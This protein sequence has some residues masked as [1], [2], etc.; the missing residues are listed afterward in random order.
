MRAQRGLWYGAPLLIAAACA[1][2]GAVDE[3]AVER[4]PQRSP[5]GA[6]ALELLAP[7][8]ALPALSLR[9]SLQLVDGSYRARFAGEVAHP[10]VQ[11]EIPAV[12]GDA[13][14]V[15]DGRSAVAMRVRPRSVDSTVPS[16]AS[17]AAERVAGDVV[18]GKVLYRDALGPGSHRVHAPLPGGSEELV[19]V[20]RAAGAPVALAWEVE[21]GGA[22]AGVRLVSGT[23]EVLDAGGAPRLRMAR[24][25]LQDAAGTRRW[26]QV[27]LGGCAHDTSP[28]PP[29]G[30]SPVSPGGACTVTLRWDAGDLV[31]P[32]L[33]DPLWSTADSLGTPRGH[34]QATL[35]DDGR[36][37]VS[38][39][40]SA[41][42]ASDAA[43]ATAEI[44]DP[45]TDSWAATAGMTAARLEHVAALLPDGRVL[46]AGGR[47]SWDGGGLASA[48]TFD[49]VGGTF[50]ATGSM[51]VGRAGA[52]A[53]ALPSGKVL[54]TGGIDA[55]G[56][57]VA[58]AQ[59]YDSIA[60]A[61]A[62]AS[63]FVDARAH[64][65]ATTLVDGRVLVLGGHQNTPS[66]SD[67]YPTSASVFDEGVGGWQPVADWAATRGWH[68]A[69]RLDD[70][71]VAVV[72]GFIPS[73]FVA[74]TNLY[75]P[76]TDV[77]SAGPDLPLGREQH[78]ATLLGNGNVLVTGG[79]VTGPEPG[80][81]YPTN[82]AWLLAAD[83]S[84]WAPVEPTV[85]YRYG[86]TGTRLDDGRV[87]LA[88]GFLVDGF[89]YV[90]QADVEIY[91]LLPGGSACATDGECSTGF[92]RD[93]VCCD[94]ACEGTC[95]SCNASLK[96]GGEDG[97]CGFI[98]AGD[99][100]QDEC[101]D[102]G[103]SACMENGLCDGAGACQLYDGG[104]VAKPCAEGAECASGI[105]SVDG[106]CCNAAC[107]GVCESCLKLVNGAEEGKC[108]PVL[109]GTDPD[110]EC[111]ST[112]DTDCSAISLCNGALACAPSASLCAPYVCRD[113][114]AC[115]IG[116]DDDADCV[117]THR[118]DDGACVV[119]EPGCQGSVAVTADGIEIECSPYLCMADGTCRTTCGSA[120]DCA[121]GFVCD[122]AG[123]CVTV[124][125]SDGAGDDGCGCRL[126]GAPA[127]PARQAAWLLGA[128]LLLRR[129]RGCRAGA[130]RD[131]LRSGGT[132]PS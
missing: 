119:R 6:D 106:I 41:N 103:A 126:A 113:D 83:A 89:N 127:A 115:R 99:D 40:S 45:V 18:A 95:V 104:C 100:P 88:G 128:A 19:I 96:G 43:Y 81:A 118:C 60:D 101:L 117:T 112:S 15:R 58:S 20:E 82:D 86:H 28:A 105:C 114:T 29:W 59:T 47:S 111:P 87:L 34:H 50:T 44:Y 129:R 46:V 16:G 72:G 36:V 13:L 84:A 94:T 90:A 110:H 130:S 35:L 32:I 65:T 70:G 49:P 125:A 109:L 91:A 80:V 31:Y 25:W 62:P 48:E 52:C 69:T 71:R 5:P 12:A 1:G 63:S 33:V 14:L 74:V 8:S 17:L 30:R 9:P 116:C 27:E 107:G 51:G 38:G 68:T 55:A 21:L 4:G 121:E 39:G 67:S 42:F 57:V 24:P 122:G 11:V 98:A 56:S 73:V 26:A 66:S 22:A 120:A 102:G 3:A 77:W 76:T 124:A 108:L 123:Q 85:A 7:W 61:W 37:L 75:D 64:H 93:G 2:S 132:G 54:V 131:K 10:R 97:V 92:C 78:T 79:G 53:N 23:M